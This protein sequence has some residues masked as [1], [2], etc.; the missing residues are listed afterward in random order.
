MSM[1]DNWIN[2]CE[3]NDLVDNSGVCALVNDVQVAIFKICQGDKLSLYA[4]SNWDP[5]GKAN[6]MYRG[7]V[8]SVSNEPFVAS[9]LYKQRFKLISG[10]CIDDESVKIAVYPARIVDQ[11]VQLQLVN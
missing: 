11:Q 10:E 2:V 8:G 9:P 4:V 5:I 1:S 3:P 7:L 6:V